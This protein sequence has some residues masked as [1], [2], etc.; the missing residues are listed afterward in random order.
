MIRTSR[1]LAAVL[2]SGL[3]LTACGEGEL[4]PGAAAIVGEDRITTADLQG[5][6][7]RG[8]SDPAAEQQ[9]GQDRAAFQ[10]QALSRLINRIVLEEAAEREG[11]TVNQGDVD[12]QLE[13][14]VSQAGSREALEQ[15]A[16]QSGIAP[17]D[18]PRFLRDVVLDQALGDALTED[19][20]VPQEQ[21]QSLYQENIGQYDRVRSRHI[22]VETEA[23]ARSIL[24]QVR[25]DESRFAPLAAQFSTDT[26]NKD[27]GGDLGL[28]GRGQFVPEFEELLF[29]AEEGTY[30][31]VQ[32]QFG[33]HVVNVIERETTTLAEATPELR[34]AAL[35]AERQE[36]TQAL[37]QEVSADLGVKVNPRFGAWDAASGQVQPLDDPNDVT[38]PDAGDG[39]G[40]APVEDEA[41][42]LDEGAVEEPAPAPTQ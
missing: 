15:Q 7:D 14:F 37:L 29:S 34:R 2:L 31:V 21:L 32:T 30:D 20:D 5:V 25:A 24:A 10:R 23:Q 33:W 28:A 12:A 3:L 35:Q 19:V 9:L 38:T 1:R 6:V 8:L 39:G 16:A 26:S 11:V 42:L 4:R 36:R 18:L 22:L 40:E 17:Q 27:R 41:P 13:R